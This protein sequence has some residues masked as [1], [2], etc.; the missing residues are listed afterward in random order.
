MEAAFLMPMLL[1]VI[2]GSILGAFY[3]HDKNILT[4]AVYETAVVGSGKMREKGGIQE[5]ELEAFFQ[6]RTEGKCI[7]FAGA[8]VAVEVKEKE[9]R[10]AAVASRK[11]MK[12]KVE[13]KM[14]VT[15]PEQTIRDKEKGK[16]LLHGETSYSGGRGIIPGGLPDA[17]APAE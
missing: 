15:M 6:E 17:D 16:G 1:F 12:V 9:I 11:K 10:V 13:R 2:M 8:E 5:E 4:A 3:Y 14:P 7:L